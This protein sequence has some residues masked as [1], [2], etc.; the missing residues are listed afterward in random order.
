MRWQSSD[1]VLRLVVPALLAVACSAQSQAAEPELVGILAAAVD[2]ANAKAIDLSDAQ[3]KQLLDLIDAREAEAV[4]LAMKLKSLPPVERFRQLEPFRRASEVKG[5]ALL[6][7]GQRDRLL[8]IAV[9]RG[10]LAS[11]GEGSLADRLELTSDQRKAVEDALRNRAERLTKTEGLAAS[12]IIAEAEKTIGSVLTDAQRKTLTALKTGTTAAPAPAAAA[13]MPA[14][15]VAP[16]AGAS[17]PVPATASTNM[18]APAPATVAAPAAASST[19]VAP[20][21]V[22]TAEAKPATTA[23]A[24]PAETK[25]AA[26]PAETKPTETKSAEKPAA[27]STPANVA[28]PAVTGGGPATTLVRPTN[29]LPPG[30]TVAAPAAAAPAQVK[31]RFSFRFQPWKDVL[32]WFAQQAGLSLV[33]DAPPPGTFNYS[34]DREY[35]PAEAIDLL[36][37]VLLTKGFTLVRRERMLMLINLQDGIPANLVTSITPEELDNKGNYELTSVVFNLERLSPEEAELEAKKMIGPQGSVVLLPGARQMMITETA[38]RLRAIR[39]M[40]KRIES[41]D[42]T[43]VGVVRIYDLRRATTQTV[44]DVLRQLLDIPSDKFAASDGSVRFALDN[45]NQRLLVSGKP[46][47]LVRVDDILKALDVSLVTGGSPSGVGAPQLEVYPITGADA[48]SVL[49]VLQTLMNGAPDVRLA[50]DAKAGTLVALARP[51]QQATIKATLAQMQRDGRRVEVI[52]LRTVDPQ[53]AA[54]SIGKLFT[55]SGTLA[56]QVDADPNARQ[57]LVRATESQLTQIRSLLEKLGE[58]PPGES[59]AAGPNVRTIPLTGRNARAA[60][61][62]IQEIWPALHKNKIRIVTP[63]STIPTQKTSGEPA[64]T[65][66]EDGPTAA[67][68]DPSLLRLLV[69]GA[70]SDIRQARPNAEPAAPAEKAP[71]PVAPPAQKAPPEAAPPSEKPKAA[72][73]A[74]HKPSADVNAPRSADKSAA[75]PWARMVLV[76]DTQPAPATSSGAKPATHAPPAAAA[77]HGTAPAGRASQADAEPAPIIVA[78]GPGGIMIASEDPEALA[79]FEQLLHSLAPNASSSSG[80]L[81]I[82][83]LKHAKAAVVADTLDRILGGG[84][85][86]AGSSGGGGAGGGR[87]SFLGDLA[88]AAFGGGGG[89]GGGG[90]GGGLLGSIFGGSSSGSITPTGPVRITPDSRLNALVIQANATDMDMV[91]QLLKILD[92][93]ESPEDILVTPKPRIIPVENAEAT[94]IANILRSVYQDRLVGS[95]GGQGGGAGGQGGMMQRGPSPLDFFAMLRGGAGSRRGGPGGMGGF[96]GMTG[97]GGRGS[98]QVE[99]VQR[100]SIGVDENT[101]SLIVVAP[102][103]LFQE[104]KQLV[105]QL[106]EAASDSNDTTRI[107]TLERS[108]MGALAQALGSIGNGSIQVSIASGTSKMSMPRATGVAGGAA[109]AGGGYSGP[110]GSSVRRTTAAPTAVSAQ[111]QAAARAVQPQQRTNSAAQQRNAAAARTGAANTAN[112][113][114]AATNRNTQQRAGTGGATQQRNMGGQQQRSNTNRTGGR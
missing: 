76:A 69:P 112:R 47:R 5:F 16:S 82:F 79:E 94:D 83:Y 100:M 74:E 78:P 48:Q 8:A 64:E 13:A 98:A 26:T 63:S 55:E 109:Q 6:Q 50:L 114:P 24:T 70:A 99:D 81:T 58:G 9:E 12:T 45:A 42:V 57:L 101:N 19:T 102:D 61:D 85:L 15:T 28:A 71:A 110:T 80:D 49:N 4:G 37:S 67:P 31:L 107:V 29:A 1:F 104:I 113:Q 27:T 7:P 35:T 53:V 91:E 38:G 52:P 106:D 87:G 54:I 86:P 41:P 84:T 36:N 3:R 97:A 14:A 105:A 90:D 108:N 89:G 75:A 30:A 2:P 88:G 73:A 95:G 17:A 10:G 93:K 11:L 103:P 68:I 65:T 22:T 62:K 77:G 40:L 32:D 33:L 72:S 59:A 18:T 21:A 51:D 43:G 111:G 46:E 56:P 60:L 44:L 23:A 25:P 34:D 96:G 39:N 92:Q 66:E 20:P